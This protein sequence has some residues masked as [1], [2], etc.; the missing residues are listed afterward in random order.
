[1]KLKSFFL[2]FLFILLSIIIFIFFYYKLNN[3]LTVA[4]SSSNA[5]SSDASSSNA[6]SSDASSSNASSS[7]AST[8]DTSSSEANSSE[9]N[10]SEANSSTANSSTANSSTANSS[11]AKSSTANSSTAKSSTAKSSSKSNYYLDIDT[12]IYTD[13]ADFST[14]PIDYT[15]ISYTPIGN[16]SS[17]PIKSSQQITLSANIQ[18]YAAQGLYQLTNINQNIGELVAMNIGSFAV[19]LVIEELAEYAWKN[20]GKILIKSNIHQFITEISTTGEF[21]A[22]MLIEAGE[23]A[24]I[25]I[26]EKG[27]LASL[28]SSLKTAVQSGSKIAIETAKA[29]FAVARTA[30]LAGTATTMIT[31]ILSMGPIG[32]ALL[33]FDLV[34]ILLDVGDAGG[35]SILDKWNMV[36]NNIKSR[37]NK[38]IVDSKYPVLVGPF[39]ELILQP[40]PNIDQSEINKLDPEDLIDEDTSVSEIHNLFVYKVNQ[41]IPLVTQKLLSEGTTG[42]LMVQKFAELVVTFL[43]KIQNDYFLPEYNT[44]VISMELVDKYYDTTTNFIEEINNY[45]IPGFKNIVQNEYDEQI[46][47][48]KLETSEFS[49]EN[50]NIIADYAVKNVC[51]ENNGVILENGKC[52]FKKESCVNNNPLGEYEIRRIWDNQNNMCVSLNGVISHICKVNS[53]EYNSEKGMCEITDVMCK[54]KGGEIRRLNDGTIDCFIPDAQNFFEMLFGTTVIRGLK[55]IFDP[56]QYTK[57]NENENDL[58]YACA[59]QCNS[60]YKFLKDY[61][62]NGFDGASDST[63]NLIVDKIRAT[64]STTTETILGKESVGIATAALATANPLT[65]TVAASIILPNI[66]CINPYAKMDDNCDAGY[67]D[68]GLTCVA[69]PVTIGPGITPELTRD[70]TDNKQYENGLCYSQ[71]REGYRSDGATQCYYDDKRLSYQQGYWECDRHYTDY[72]GTSITT[73]NNILAFENI[74]AGTLPNTCP[75][76]QENIGGLCYDRCRDGYYSEGLMCYGGDR[77]RPLIIS[78]DTTCDENYHFNGFVCVRKAANPN[79]SVGISP[80][81]LNCGNGWKKVNPTTCVKI[82]TK[83]NPNNG[84]NEEDSDYEIK[85]HDTTNYWL[86]ENKRSYVIH[87]IEPNQDNSRCND[88]KDVIYGVG[89]CTGWK[90]G[91]NTKCEGCGCIKGK[92]NIQGKCVGKNGGRRSDGTSC[93]EDWKCKTTGG[94]LTRNV[95]RHCRDGFEFDDLNAYCYPKCR[96]GYKKR[97]GDIVT[98]WNE[99]PITKPIPRDNIKIETQCASDRDAVGSLCYPKCGD[100]YKRNGLNCTP[101]EMKASCPD[102]YYQ[103]LPTDLTCTK[104]SYTRVSNGRIGCGD[105]DQINGLCYKK[106]PKDLDASGNDLETGYTRQQT[107][108]CLPP[109]GASYEKEKKK[110]D[111]GFSEKGGT[112]WRDSYLRE[113]AIPYKCKSNRELVGGMCYQKCEKGVMVNDDDKVDEYKR[114]DGFPTQCVPPKGLMYSKIKSSYITEIYGKK[115]EV[116]FSVK[117]EY[118]LR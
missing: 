71:C 37:Y 35:Y 60:G 47:L 76:G 41:M 40:P 116:P 107:I 54:T 25:R 19:S 108:Q 62:T 38:L 16:T 118:T 83:F 70:C 97:P 43:S 24:S 52:M 59:K 94:I 98:C 66:L 111:N 20:S 36:I 63:K 34:S 105:K 6:S 8:S 117:Q 80:T 109:K 4:A 21:V 30:T 1:M 96:D 93:W 65:G 90:D 33:I 106:C 12:N 110:C 64:Y 10:S 85:D 61:I 32:L 84:M 82:L 23:K 89:T 14:E 101:N 55:Q 67:N 79:T 17:T 49:T 18:A 7:D 48:M 91:L 11:T 51:I 50:F 95:P 58:T 77:N 88:L 86:K 31:T 39:D 75:P 74:D 68:T 42:Q 27:S 87:Y 44:I 100:G 112:C 78:I 56:D 72:N 45:I 92:A 99:K 2:F 29:A 81:L 115:R 3:K 22:N 15:N 114:A 5:S 28:K 69:K 13:I 57:C 103:L 102:G 46:K 9:A 26:A 104:R 73:C 113:S 53:L